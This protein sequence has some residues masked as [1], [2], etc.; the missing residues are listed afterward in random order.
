M[1]SVHEEIE[2]RI[3]RRKK[4]DIIFQSDFRGLGTDAAVR[5][6]LSRLTQ[7]NT[8]KRLSRGIYYLPTVDP[9][10]G[11]LAPSI[12]KVLEKISN[13][14]RIRIKPT[15]VHALYKLGLTTQVPTRQ[16]YLTD[17]N[18]RIIRIGKTVI[19]LKH[20]TP[21][22]LS[23]IG[24]LSGLIISALDELDTT[25]L[26]ADFKL[27][28]GSLLQKEDQKKLKH[29]IGLA[30]TKISDFLFSILKEIQ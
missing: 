27:K 25:S 23:H 3:K 18:R 8:I 11:E 7:D 2:A 6:V 4:G 5:K 21:K 29:D 24:E 15:G 20:V 28:I 17:G 10:F 9:I 19:Q 30:P 14:E 12:E 16:V 13:K 26:S 1:I 22:K